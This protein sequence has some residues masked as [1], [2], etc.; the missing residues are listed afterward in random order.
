MRFET[1]LA[2][3]R[4]LMAVFKID[5]TTPRPFITRI[6]LQETDE[7]LVAMR[8]LYLV[9]FPILHIGFHV[10]TLVVLARY[11]KPLWG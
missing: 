1:T 10:T 3:K 4:K 7:A 11:S 8:I 6:S 2:R 9:P 5:M